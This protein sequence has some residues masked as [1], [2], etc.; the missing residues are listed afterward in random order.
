MTRAAT[1]SGVD[2]KDAWL[3]ATMVTPTLVLMV[4]LVFAPVLLTLWDSLHRVNPMQAGTPFIGLANYLRSF[5]ERNVLQSWQNT[6]AYVALAVILETVGG[7]LIA[8]LLHRLRWGRRWLLAIVV[9]PWALP[10][11]V[12][13]ILWAWIYN[14][15]AGVLTQIA[16]GLGLVADHHVWLNDRAGSL[17]LVAIVHVW[18]VLPLTAVIVL[19]ALQSIPTELYEAARIDGTSSWRIFRSV[20]LPLISGSL[21]IALTQSTVT[22]FNLFDEAWVLNGS[23]LDTRSVLIQV[24]LSAFQDLKFSYGMAISVLVM[25][26]SLVASGLYAARVYS[27]TRYE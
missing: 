11:V 12:N 1:D 3:G 15:S 21:A 16:H 19:A 25:I 2:Q 4:A 23:S 17:L 7:V 6:I 20:T 8:L 22:A 5:Q 13:A 18:R 24:Y 26:V 27:E 14:P 10:P 9:L